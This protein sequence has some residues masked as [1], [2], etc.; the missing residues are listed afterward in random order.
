MLTIETTECDLFAFPCLMQTDL[1]KIVL[2]TAKGT[3]VAL[4]AGEGSV[5]GVGY[6]CSDWA[7]DAF[8][9]FVG[10]ITLRQTS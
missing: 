7:M 10:M 6:F 5:D 8:F 9:P 3:G 4:V 1:G 2:M